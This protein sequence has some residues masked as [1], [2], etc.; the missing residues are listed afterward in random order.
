MENYNVIIIGGGP[1]G[2]SAA[3]YLARANIKTAIVENGPGALARAHKIENFYG[4]AASGIKLYAEGLEQA[5]SLGVDIIQDEVLAVEYYDSFVLTL[6]HA[7]EPL[8]APA[9]IL[10]TGTKNVTL[11]L[12]GLVELEGKGI[13]YCAVCDGFFFR[14]KKL[15]V[16]GHGAFALHEAEYLRHIAAE[17]TVLTNGQDDSAAKAAG[18]AT[19]TTPVTAVTGSEK[20]E[21]VRF[22]D[23]S[24]LEVSGLF[25]ALGTADSTDIARKLG[26]QLDGRF[27][28]VDA[29]GATNIPGLFAAGDCIGGLRQV[30]KAVHDGA[31]AGLATVKFLRK[32]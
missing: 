1:A 3:L 20:L 8:P 28:K 30:A 23:G 22:A 19:I 16:L 11:N 25:I 7:A 26:A 14:K 5:R 4:I 17:V 24:E 10:A 27:I 12:P 13:S 2:V 6:K 31:R 9:L 32:Q 21:A 18:F 15:A 29:D